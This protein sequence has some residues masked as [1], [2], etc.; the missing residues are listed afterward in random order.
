MF[1]YLEW[2][3]LKPSLGSQDGFYLEFPFE[4]LW[5]TGICDPSL[6]PFPSPLHINTQ[7]WEAWGVVVFRRSRAT[8][9]GADSIW[10]HGVTGVDRMVYLK[11]VFSN[12]HLAIPTTKAW[13]TVKVQD[14]LITLRRSFYNAKTLKCH[15]ALGKYAELLCVNQKQTWGNICGKS[16]CYIYIPK[17]F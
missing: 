2:E 16:M 15:M 12:I 9:F 10:V 1:C 4:L 6:D 3:P 5:I 17:W 8:A 7:G 13:W 11:Y 14:M